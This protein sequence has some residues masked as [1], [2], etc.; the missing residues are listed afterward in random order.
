MIKLSGGGTGGGGEQLSPGPGPPPPVSPAERADADNNDATIAATKCVDGIPQGA[1][2][3]MNFVLQLGTVETALDKKHGSQ[4]SSALLNQETS[5]IVVAGNE[6]P[7]KT[8]FLS[9]DQGRQR[10]AEDR[11]LP[12]EYHSGA[13]YTRDLA[14]IAILKPPAAGCTCG[15]ERFLSRD[16]YVGKFSGPA[17]LRQ[18]SGASIPFAACCSDTGQAAD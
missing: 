13:D 2:A 11:R 1:E 16:S 12:N 3:T 9:G 10:D 6:D 17:V 18:R 7:G 4:S 15:P 14:E 5:N 8:Q